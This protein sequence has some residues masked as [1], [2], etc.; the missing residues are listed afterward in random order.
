LLLFNWS[1]FQKKRRDPSYPDKP[2]AQSILF[3]VA[4][5]IAFTF[6]V[7][8]YRGIMYYQMILF[9]IVA[10]VLFWKIYLKK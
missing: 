6:L 7:D 9:L 1:Y 5:A 10:A 3:P 8:A 4:L 2:I